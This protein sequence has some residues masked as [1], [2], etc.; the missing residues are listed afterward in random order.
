M[1]NYCFGNAVYAMA[2]VTISDAAK[3]V[4]K[5]RTTLMRDIE[6]GRLAKT[7][8]QDGDVRIDTAELLR[9]YGRLHSP[10]AAAKPSE[11]RKISAE[12]TRIALLEERIRSLERVIT[13]EAEL[14][15]VKDQVTTELRVRLAD[16]DHLIKILE[17][18]ILFLE[19]DK[20][21]QQTR[22]VPTLE[23]E[24]P[25]PA[26]AAKPAEA[27]APA[28]TAATNKSAASDKTPINNK[29]VASDKSAVSAA[30]AKAAAAG[31]T[32]GAA[33]TSRAAGI[34][35]AGTTGAST[36][37]ATTAATA[38]TVTTG[39]TPPTSARA[40]PG[41]PGGMERRRPPEHRHGWWRRIFGGGEPRNR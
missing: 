37:T 27:V 32:A 20:Q 41:A 39:S 24:Q 29:T 30:P 16:K 33:G 13:L 36:T 2:L 3:L 1:V 18:K 9:F 17:S 38:P 19:Y 40:V 4:R 12:K 11:S 22:Q 8:L 15:R 28:A 5:A 35:A 31:A 10:Q 6:N 14:R 34:A 21:T 25:A 7:V 23:P 26:P